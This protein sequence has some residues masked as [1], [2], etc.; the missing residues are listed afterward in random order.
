HGHLA[1]DLHGL[2]LVEF[3][4][5][6]VVREHG[7]AEQT[8]RAEATRR[9]RKTGNHERRCDGCTEGADC[10]GCFFAAARAA[11]RMSFRCFR[12]WSSSRH[13]TSSSSLFWRRSGIASVHGRVYAPGSVT[14]ASYRMLLASIGM[15]RST[16]CSW[17]VTTPPNSSSQVLPLR[18]LVSITS[19]S[20][21]Q[22]PTES[23]CH[24]RIESSRCLR[25]SSG[26]CRHDMRSYSST[27]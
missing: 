7:R 3:G 25:P 2:V 21:S 24:S 13:A 22:W 19:V 4:G 18:F 15:N 27:T 10:H 1:G 20:P 26:T 14:V 8:C 12:S 23:P 11:S 17:C 5:E 6:R 16:T 9:R